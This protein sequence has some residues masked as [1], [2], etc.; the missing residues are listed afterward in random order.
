M[1]QIGQLI[2]TVARVE[3]PHTAPRLF[4]TY[5]DEKTVNGAKKADGSDNIIYTAGKYQ[6]LVF[7]EV[8][9][10]RY[11]TTDGSKRVFLSREAAEAEWKAMCRVPGNMCSCTA[12]D[13]KYMEQQELIDKVAAE[14]GCIVVR[15]SSHAHN[16]VP[17]TVL[18]YLKDDARHNIEVDM[19]PTRYSRQEAAEF[20]QAT[21]KQIDQKYIYRDHLWFFQNTDSNGLYNPNF[22]NLGKLDLRG[23][24]WNSVI[25]GSI[26]LAYYENL[27]LC[28]AYGSGGYTA[29][30][31]ADDTY[32]DL[33]RRIIDAFY[34]AHGKAYMGSINLSDEKRKQ[35]AN[36]TCCVFEEYTG[37]MV[38]NFGCSFVVP[39]A[40][41]YLEELILDWNR[42]GWPKQQPLVCQ[43][44]DAIE[45]IGGLNFLWY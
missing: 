10:G 16:N 30:R 31:E 36:G 20:K 33:N 5:V 44:A 22:A 19:E 6:E 38:Y 45:R 41:K 18:L 12:F 17:Q 24:H 25:E 27:Q 23:D 32:N 26:K 7:C 35:L 42:G 4:R 40:D 3:I 39:I 1:L 43:I 2:F 37:Q 8:S 11:Q 21:G 29:L 34:K 15:I 9:P 14:L 13:S 28:Y